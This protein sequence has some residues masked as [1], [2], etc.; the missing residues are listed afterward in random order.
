M[1]LG[2]TN[3]LFQKE[4]PRN[5]T[6]AIRVYLESPSTSSTRFYGPRSLSFEVLKPSVFVVWLWGQGMSEDS[7]AQ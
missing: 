3:V 5:Q 2:A 7:K 6:A 4:D 1:F